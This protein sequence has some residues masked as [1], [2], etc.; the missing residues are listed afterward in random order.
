MRVLLS[1]AR[2]IPARVSACVIVCRQRSG[3][4]GGAFNSVS[5]FAYYSLFR[6]RVDAM[7]SVLPVRERDFRLQRDIMPSG[8][9]KGR[10]ICEMITGAVHEDRA[11][12]KRGRLI[13]RLDLS[14]S[15]SA[16]SSRWPLTRDDALSNACSH[17][18]NFSS[19]P[20]SR[21]SL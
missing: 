15:R 18:S 11:R 1:L 6:A 16:I 2:F 4:A 3:A 7:M 19:T 12:P 17:A 9:R 21:R 20:D 10:A 8:R 5:A 13:R 14:F